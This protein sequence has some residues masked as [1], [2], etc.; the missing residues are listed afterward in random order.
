[1]HNFSLG[2]ALVAVA[3]SVY[4]RESTVAK[5][6]K[7]LSKAEKEVAILRDEPRHARIM[8]AEI[9]DDNAGFRHHLAARGIL[10]HRKF[11][12]TPQLQQDRAL[13]RIAEIDRHG[14]E[15]RGVLMERD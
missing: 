3:R 12:D 6:K 5:A 4:Q 15:R 1:M 10:Q 9:L 8:P 7:R 2:K 14:R 11:A 13:I